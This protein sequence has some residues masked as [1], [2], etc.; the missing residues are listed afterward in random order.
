MKDSA[1]KAMFAKFSQID[2]QAGKNNLE[3]G[4]LIIKRDTEGLTN[5]D[6]EKMARFKEQYHELDS[7]FNKLRK[8]N[9][10]EHKAWYHSVKG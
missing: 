7:E 1:R 8:Q 5:Q 2:K 3:L 10:E 6:R 9:P 4:R